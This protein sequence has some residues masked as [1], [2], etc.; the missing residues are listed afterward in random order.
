MLAYK[1][2]NLESLQV[3]GSAYRLVNRPLPFEEQPDLSYPDLSS[4]H[5]G[6]TVQGLGSEPEAVNGYLFSTL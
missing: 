6:V 2:T 1:P 3:A 4:L 5:S